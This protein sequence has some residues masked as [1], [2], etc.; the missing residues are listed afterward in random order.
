RGSI[1]ETKRDVDAALADLKANRERAGLFKLGIIPQ[2]SQTVAAMLSAYQVDKADFLNLV[3]SE[4][5]LYN[6]ETEY[7]KALSSSWQAW[8][9]LQSETGAP[10]NKDT[11]HE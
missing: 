8:A 10:V 4:I 5:T 1:H 11:N 6:Y 9:I 3:R 7:W 2:A